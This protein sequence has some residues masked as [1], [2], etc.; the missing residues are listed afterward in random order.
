V[1]YYSHSGS[2]PKLAEI[3]ARL[4]GGD[5]AALKPA[6]PYPGEGAGLDEAL[7]EE[8]RLG[9]LPWLAPAYPGP[10]GYWVV[11]AGSPV[12]RSGLAGPV[13]SWLPKFDFGGSVLALFL[14]HGGRGG[15]RCLSDLASHARGAAVEP[16]ILHVRS[17]GAGGLPGLDDAGVLSWL[18][19]IK[20]PGTGRPCYP[21]L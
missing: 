18:R 11:L 21:G 16:V 1:V 14:T 10:G 17:D 2:T 12:W 4:S 15:G 9:A 5:L 8:E 20:D 3:V 13:R 6:S 19:G 7:D